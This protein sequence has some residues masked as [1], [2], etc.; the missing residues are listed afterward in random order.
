MERTCSPHL[1]GSLSSEGNE[2]IH[3]QHQDMGLGPEAV[4][5]APNMEEGV[6]VTLAERGRLVQVGRVWLPCA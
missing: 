4:G 6:G 2:E 5:S 3:R 1:Q